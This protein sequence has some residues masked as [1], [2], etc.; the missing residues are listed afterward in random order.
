MY[1]EDNLCRADVNDVQLPGETRSHPQQF[2]QGRNNSLLAYTGRY[3]HSMQQVT[4][5]FGRR[6]PPEQPGSNLL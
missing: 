4:T 5:G 1:T 2:R 6:G 3:A